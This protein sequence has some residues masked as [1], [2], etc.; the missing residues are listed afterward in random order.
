MARPQDLRPLQAVTTHTMYQ[1]RYL[2]AGARP[3]SPAISQAQFF[4]VDLNLLSRD[5]VRRLVSDVEIRTTAAGA[6]AARDVEINAEKARL[7]KGRTRGTWRYFYD[8]PVS[9]PITRAR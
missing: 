7:T 1:L 3:A 5:G 9:Y 6:V 4:G 2:L 8:T